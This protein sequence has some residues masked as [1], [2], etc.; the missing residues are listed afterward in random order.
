[1]EIEFDAARDYASLCGSVIAVLSTFYFWLVR[2]NRER[3]NLEIHPV[4]DLEGCLILFNEDSET[5]QRLRPGKQEHCVKYWL[6]LA[7]V[8]NSSLP[9]AIL[10]VR[11]WLQ[12][13]N[14]DWQPMDVRHQTPNEDLIPINIDPLTTASLK[15]SLAMLYSAEIQNDFAGRAAAAG[16][17]L[18]REIPIRIELTGL[19]ERQF[20][21]TFSDSGNG[22]KRSLR[23]DRLNAA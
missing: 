21:K 20:G 18:P 1:M 10:G 15:L 6:R 13:R 2:S 16:D 17:A 7:V 5:Y 19:G 22:L 8:N 9:N 3:P 23:S 12:R 4:S 14:G 11:V